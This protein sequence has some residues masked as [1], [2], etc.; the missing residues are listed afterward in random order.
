MRRGPAGVLVYLNTTEGNSALAWMDQMW[1]GLSGVVG[2]AIGDS[3]LLKAFT[4]ILERFA[5]GP[6]LLI[7]QVWPPCPVDMLNCLGLCTPALAKAS[8]V[9]DVI[10]VLLNKL[11]RICRSHTADPYAQRYHFW[12]HYAEKHL[13]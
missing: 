9:P 7:R 6:R 11:L 3:A 2:L 13:A 8:S 1:I 4:L 5:Q 12:L 10:V